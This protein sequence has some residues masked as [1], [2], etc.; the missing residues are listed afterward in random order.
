MTCKALIQ[1]YI[2]IPLNR[3]RAI[4]RSTC[5]IR[6]LRRE[7][8]DPIED[9]RMVLERR[10]DRRDLAVE[11]RAAGQQGQ[12]IEIA[13]NRPAPP[14][15]APPRR[16]RRRCR[17]HSLGAEPCV[18][19]GRMRS[20]AA[21][22]HDDRR[23]RRSALSRDTIFRSGETPRNSNSRG[24]QMP[25][26]C[27]RFVR[28][29]TPARSAGLDKRS[30]LASARSIRSANAWGGDR[31]TAAPGPGRWRRGG[32]HVAGTSHGAPRKPMKPVVAGAAPLTRRWSRNWRE[33]LS[34]GGTAAAL[35]PPAFR[36]AQVL[37][38]AGLERDSSAERVGNTR[39]SLNKMPRRSETAGWGPSVASTAAAGEITKSRNLAALARNSRYPQISRG[40]W[41]ISHSGDRVGFPRKTER[42]GFSS[43]FMRRSF[44]KRPQ[45]RRGRT[46]PVPWFGSRQGAETA[47]R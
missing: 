43:A 18:R 15:R 38:L 4:N 10:E 47:F 28:P 40:S 31:R 17:A 14:F 36:S 35:C 42:S 32:D 1:R 44:E 9:M 24:W 3:D 5:S 6:R 25:P 11:R 2:V 20:G 23:R 33:M 26:S 37:T 30:R 12:W 27:R 7:S 29:S 46:P 34:I 13:C 16:R 19:P 39:W 41:R 45:W 8:R 21:R 22:E